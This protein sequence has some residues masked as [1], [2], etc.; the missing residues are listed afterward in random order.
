MDA[1]QM[2]I[3]LNLKLV[4]DFKSNYLHLANGNNANCNNT[5]RVTTPTSAN[6]YSNTADE[7]N[8]RR[9]TLKIQKMYEASS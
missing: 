8:C 2:A 4:Q 7:L 6:F 5:Y 3:E 9:C 1:I